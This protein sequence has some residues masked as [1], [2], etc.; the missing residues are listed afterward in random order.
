MRIR[1]R[2]AFR[3][4]VSAVLFCA[5]T[6]LPAT[7]VFALD[8]PIGS[9][10]TYQGRLKQG[11]Q[12]AQGTFDLKFRLYDAATDGN[13][14]GSELSFPGSDVDEGFFTVDLDFGPVHAGSM[15]WLEVQIND[16]VLAPRQA[17]RPTPTEIGRAHV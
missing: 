16:T 17:L 15:R 3:S 7:P 13:Q 1:F 10:F 14:I 4:G 8:M 12:P 11:S 5:A 9:A 2:S 6:F